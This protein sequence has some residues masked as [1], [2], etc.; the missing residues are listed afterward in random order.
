MLA[1]L[2]AAGGLLFGFDAS[3]FRS[4]VYRPVIEPQSYAGQTDL[5]LRQAALADPAKRNVLVLGDS[6]IAEGFSSQIA[7]R[8]AGAT[9]RFVN[10]AVPGS[11]LRCWYY[12]LREV[13]PTS[14]RFQAIVLPFDDYEDED[15]EWDWA[16]RVLDL[17]IVA[18]CL[19]LNDIWDFT[20]S[21]RGW[22]ERFEA[23]RGIALRGFALKDDVQDFLLHPSRRME[24]ARQWKTS[25]VGWLNGYQGN[26][27]ALPDSY[28]PQVRKLLPQNGRYSAYR[29]LWLGRILKRYEGT[30]VRVFA[31]RVPRGP[32]PQDHPAG[33]LGSAVRDVRSD[34]LTVI[35]E[36][37]FA[38]LEKPEN[39]FDDLHL[40]ARGR[41]SFSRLLAQTLR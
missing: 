30:S 18:F 24:K 12:L 5:A 2:A 34:R 15:G 22:S 38:S 4:G 11:T 9:T 10:A 37:T 1:M 14:A 40:N 8:V 20:A 25:G 36:K 23:L 28:R 32:F 27:G 16:D 6:R 7:N 29:R 3:L 31:I 41:E 17:R 21:F 39:F 35:G 19:R 33:Q 26:P 13:D